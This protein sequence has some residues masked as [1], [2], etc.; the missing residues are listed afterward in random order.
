MIDEL[1]AAAREATPGEWSIGHP[2]QER[3]PAIGIESRDW[4]IADVW[5]GIED[6]EN[7]GTH[8][9]RHIAAC[10][11]ERII[12]LCEFVQAFTTWHNHPDVT[13]H[14]YEVAYTEMI[15]AYRRLS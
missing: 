14:T 6:L 2:N 9:A 8:N 5:T 3:F 7:E 10:S 13:S 15:G 1:L 4:T 11:P 12:A